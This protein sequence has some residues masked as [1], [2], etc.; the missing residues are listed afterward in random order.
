MQSHSEIF[1]SLFK[2]SF[3][4][5]DNIEFLQRM[6]DK[7]PFFAPAQFYLLGQTKN[8]TAAFESQAAKTSILFNNPFWLNYQLEQ[9]I[10]ADAKQQPEYRE[11]TAAETA[12][13]EADAEPVVFIPLNTLRQEVLTEPEE[14]EEIKEVL[15]EP[16]MIVQ[17]EEPITEEIKESIPELV[18][19]QPEERVKEEPVQQPVVLSY[20][21]EPVVFQPL[22]TTDYFASQGIKLSEE[23]LPTDKLGVQLKSFTEWLRTMKKVHAERLPVVDVQTDEKIQTQAERSNTNADVVTEAMAEV[24]VQQGL[25]Q[26]AI[27]VYE[28]L[29]LLSP[30][31]SV[32]FAAKIEQ[33]NKS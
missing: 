30:A 21:T 18:M 7:Y 19:T 9:L 22:Y 23:V 6:A 20:N 1:E 8:E 33:L 11:D 13:K 28:K 14:K 32:Y 16:E 29:S 31:K 10:K 5:P 4:S 24:L 2:R 12:V 17:P 27:E 25:K 26:K 3:S 15:P